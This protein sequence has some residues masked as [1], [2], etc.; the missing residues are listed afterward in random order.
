MQG[1]TLSLS[2]WLKSKPQDITSV[3]KDM[4]KKEHSWTVG[5]NVNCYSHYGKQYGGFS[6]KKIGNFTN[7][8][9]SNLSVHQFTN[10]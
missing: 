2:E 7:W 4:E 10:G 1:I 5:G 9:G 6:F 8:Y 3:G